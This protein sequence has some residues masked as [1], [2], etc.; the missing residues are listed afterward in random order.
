MALARRDHARKLRGRLWA[1]A[2]R[3]TPDYLPD[4]YIYPTNRAISVH[5]PTVEFN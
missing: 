4:E 2:G 3:R 1:A 5:A